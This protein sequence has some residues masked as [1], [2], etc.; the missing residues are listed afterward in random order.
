MKNQSSTRIFATSIVSLFTLF[1]VSRAFASSDYLL[2]IKDEKGKTH[3]ISV[4]PDGTFTTPALKAGVY[5]F[6][7]GASNS[8]STMGSAS[9]GKMASKEDVYVWKVSKMTITC[10]IKAPRDAQSGMATG[11]RQH[12]PITIVKEWDAAS[13]HFAKSSFAVLL[14]S[15]TVDE[16]CDGLTGQIVCTSSDGKKMAMDDWSAPSA[17]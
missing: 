1:L 6:S 14:G 9:Q 15:T 12:K 3:K 2:E 10:D 13:Q 16:D 11:K 5:S 7:F 17:K 4:K 8:S